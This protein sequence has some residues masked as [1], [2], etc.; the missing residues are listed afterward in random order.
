M[1]EVMG[2]KC[3]FHNINSQIHTPLVV[4]ASCARDQRAVLICPQ[5]TASFSCGLTSNGI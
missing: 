3:L 2:Q 5:V 1:L 4:G